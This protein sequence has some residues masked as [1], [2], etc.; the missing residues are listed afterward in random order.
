MTLRA[1]ARQFRAAGST[2]LEIAAQLGVNRTTV[3]KWFGANPNSRSK[4][5]DHEQ[6]R[7]L[8]AQAVELEWEG[9]SIREIAMTLGIPRSTVHEWLRSVER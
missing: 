1:Q 6:Q 8:R 2:N 3:W 4:L 5:Y 9:R 7:R